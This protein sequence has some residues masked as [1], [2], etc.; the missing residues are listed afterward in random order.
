MITGIILASGLSRR[1]KRDKLTIK[2]QGKAIIEYVIEACINSDLDKILLVYRTEEVKEI[3]K[4]YDLKLLYNKN[5]RLGQSQAIKIGLNEIDG[6]SSFMFLMGDQPLLDSKLINRLIAEYKSLDSKILVP[7]YDGERG[8]PAIFPPKYR[9]ELL[10]VKGDK[11][12]REI[13]ARENSNIH[14]IHIK[15]SKMGMDIDTPEDLEEVKK[16]I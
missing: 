11:G 15:K 8:M 12:G 6:N 14:K 1:M 5:P 10:Q 16:W 7:Y 4:K 13:I 3:G 9:N 2:L